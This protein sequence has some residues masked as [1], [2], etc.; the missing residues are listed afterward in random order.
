MDTKSLLRLAG[1]LVA[2]LLL[3]SACGDSSES[4][5]S[6]ETNPA[7]E[8]SDAPAENSGGI[9]DDDG[10]SSESPVSNG[11]SDICSTMRQL[12]DVNPFGDITSFDGSTFTSIDDFLSEAADGAPAEIRDDLLAL[13]DGFNEFGAV[14]AKYDFN[15][16]DAELRSEL[17]SF[18]VDGLSDA[19]ER[20][21]SYMS[22]TCG[23]E[24][25]AD[26]FDDSVGGGALTDPVT[27]SSLAEAFEGLEGG[28]AAVQALVQFLG[29]DQELAECL[30]EELGEFDTSSPDPSLLTQEV[31][32]T[33]LLEVITNI[34]SG[35]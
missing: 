6:P 15:F 33:T 1:V 18:D 35:G 17:A 12:A 32:G 2:L 30:N 9:G 13:R 27:A 3:A 8:T 5:S 14:L 25:D 26:E 34:G 10:G 21:S 28:E 7:T 20:V 4:S 19:G 31:C 29:I 22:E 24:L 11:D 16:F 23:I